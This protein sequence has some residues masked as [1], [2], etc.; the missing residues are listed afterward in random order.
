MQYLQLTTTRING[1]PRVL[2]KM[3]IYL[4]LYYA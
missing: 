4:K 3:G 2:I 1:D